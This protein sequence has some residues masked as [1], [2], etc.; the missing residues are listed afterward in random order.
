MSGNSLLTID[1]VTR[2]AVMLFK[3]S[4]AFMQNIS[5]QYDDSFGI[6]G[7]KI[8]S[9]LRVRLP[10]DYVV[11]DGPGLSPQDSV[12]QQTTADIELQRSS[13]ENC[14]SV[15]GELWPCSRRKLGWNGAASLGTMHSSPVGPF[16]ARHVNY[17]WVR[18]NSC[19]TACWA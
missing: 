17:D 10:L 3:N 13:W 12:E 8:G 1:M 2:E 6:T 14:T 18:S 15:R 16:T 11:T 4:N 7:A 9:T 5:T 19:R